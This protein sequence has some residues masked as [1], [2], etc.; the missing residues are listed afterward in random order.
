MRNPS[1]CRSLRVQLCP[2]HFQELAELALL[3]PP[4]SESCPSTAPRPWR[5]R[6]CGYQSGSVRAYTDTRSSL[7]VAAAV[8]GGFI[9]PTFGAVR[10]LR[11]LETVTWGLAT[12]DKSRVLF[13]RCW[14]GCNSGFQRHTETRTMGLPVNQKNI[15]SEWVDHWGMCLATIVFEYQ[16]WLVHHRFLFIQT[17]SV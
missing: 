2:T 4:C 7:V 11:S 9:T 12:S 13:I 17:G 6:R 16:Q 10:H 3:G 1:K 5:G 15:S 8:D 14:T